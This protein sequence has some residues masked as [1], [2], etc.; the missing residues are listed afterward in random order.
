[1]VNYKIMPRSRRAV[2][3]LISLIALLIVFGMASLAFLEINTTHADFVLNSIN[4]NEKQF[5]KIK[6][7]LNFTITNPLDPDPVHYMVE[8]SNIWNDKSII[9][10][11]IA[12]NS[13][14]QVSFQR[15]LNATTLP[16]KENII[17]T[18]Q[19]TMLNFTSTNSTNSDETIIFVTINGNKCVIPIPAT[20]GDVL[21][22][23]C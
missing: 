15:Y 22:R 11:Y 10:S 16:N 1:L 12:I 21:I 8:V 18:E 4:V 3:G 2:G 20:D 6:E 19:T 5:G 17:G 14:E 9:E 23:I 13:T 7:Q